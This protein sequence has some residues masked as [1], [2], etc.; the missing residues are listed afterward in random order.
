MADKPASEKSNASEISAQK[1]LRRKELRHRA[2]SLI[3]GATDPWENT[4]EYETV[5]PEEEDE[6]FVDEETAEL[7]EDV[8]QYTSMGRELLCETI[9]GQYFIRNLQSFVRELRIPK[10]LCDLIF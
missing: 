6:E 7:A 2:Q 1:R 10:H 5:I 3:E 4:E 9:L 8:I